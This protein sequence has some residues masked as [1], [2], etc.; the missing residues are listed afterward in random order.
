VGCMVEGVRTSSE[1]RSDLSL[2][3][4]LA[5]SLYVSLSF[6]PS[7]SLSPSLSPSGN[8]HTISLYFSP[9]R[10]SCFSK[11]AL[12]TET[13]VEGG[14]SQSKS[15][16]SVNLRNSGDLE[17]SAEQGDRRQG[18]SGVQLPRCRVLVD[19]NQHTKGLK[20]AMAA[21]LALSRTRTLPPVFREGSNR[22]FQVLH[23]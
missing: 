6:S 7:I 21:V 16:T 20:P 13:K 17:R 19:A 2:T 15:G 3:H 10:S 14:T 5:L 22:L 8:A 11:T 9:T 1:E 12:H 4:S 23:M 18:C